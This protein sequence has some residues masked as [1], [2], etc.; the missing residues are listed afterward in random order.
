MRGGSGGETMTVQIDAPRAAVPDAGDRGLSEQLAAF[1]AGVRADDVPPPIRATAAWWVLD[2]LGCAVAGIDTPPGR[3]LLQHTADQA[4]A[5]VSC[6]GLA[7]GR[8]PQVAAFHNGGLSHIV[9]M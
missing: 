8:S 6:L 7:G 1:V 5:A 4:A 2:W 9:E 3:M